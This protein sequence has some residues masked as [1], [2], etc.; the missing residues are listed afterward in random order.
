MNC[1]P[2]LKAPVMGSGG[3]RIL[4]F[5]RELLPDGRAKIFRDYSGHV[6]ERLVKVSV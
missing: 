1:D 2:G 5:V 4:S 6:G 3:V